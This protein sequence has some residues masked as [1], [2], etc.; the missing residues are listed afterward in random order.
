NLRAHVLR[1]HSIPRSEEKV[2]TCHFCTCVFR[3]VSRM[4]AHINRT[5]R[6]LIA[7]QTDGNDDDDDPNKAAG[8]TDLMEMGDS[9]A[10]DSSDKEN[11]EGQDSSNRPEV[12][13]RPTSKSNRNA[14]KKSKS[15]GNLCTY[16]GKLFKKPSDLVRHIRIHTHE[17]PFKCEH[18]FR[19]F[20]V[21]STLTTHMRRHT[22][23]KAYVCR[24]CNKTF[25]S[26]GSLKIHL[27][28]HLRQKRYHCKHCL[29]RFST[30]SERALHI[31]NAHALLEMEQSSNGLDKSVVLPE[32]LIMTEEVWHKIVVRT[33]E[34]TRSME[35]YLE[36]G[37]V[38][39]GSEE[40]RPHKCTECDSRFRKT[41][42]LTIHMRTHTG[43][44]PFLCDMCP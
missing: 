17:K 42:N 16:C 37:K 2:Y 12:G 32:P 31:Q 1:L 23:I 6:D 7:K 19:S 26:Q 36:A 10:K 28:S 13:G 34:G 27:K 5:H 44:R 11:D 29:L 25:S 3:K 41:S 14:R 35:V 21:R 8:E 30:L 18:C 43:E 38:A 20:T 15:A 22:G 9:T 40:D 4:H 33:R 24:A 39:I